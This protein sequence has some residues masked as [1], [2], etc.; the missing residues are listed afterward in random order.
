LASY[1]DLLR[2]RS[3]LPF[4]AGGALSFAAPST[5]VIVLV[6]ATA[7]AYPASLSQS[8]SFSALAL[9]ILGL[10]ATVPTLAAAI[11]SGTL[12]DR[13]DRR[14]L[15]GITNIA[16]VLAT[17][18]LV[19]VLFIHPD[20]HV[21]FPGPAGFYLPMWLVIACP[22][23]AGVTT[24][25]TFFRPAFNST[26]PR[27]VP[28]A[29]LG[30][31]NGLV[32]GVAVGAN[33]A[34][35]LSATALI[36]VAGVGWAL[37]VPF[38]LFTGTG[39]AVLAMRPPA[40]PRIAPVTR[41]TADV[42]EGYRFLY[43]NKALL[44]VTAASLLIN[45]LTALAFVELGLY[46]R[47]WLGVTEAILLGAMTTGATVGAGIGTI[48]AGRL[49]FERRAGRYLILLTAGQ[50]LTIMAL[51]LSHAI[52]FS[53]PLMVLFGIFPGMSATVFLATIQAVVPNRILGRV[54]AAD[55]VGSYGLVP[56]GQYA[57]GIVTLVAGVQVTFL[58]AGAGT[59]AVAGGM[60]SFSG[61]RKLGFDPGTPPA[62]PVPIAPVVAPLPTPSV[63]PPD[64]ATPVS[65]TSRPPPPG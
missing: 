18:A 41:F 55:E 48:F 5:V 61:L 30:R 29:A 49:G 65:G 3:F 58:L 42:V 52:W 47:D 28:A 40:G 2:T 54:L 1:Q 16:A 24:A 56:I 59:V 37:L 23:W 36:M 38:A 46:V 33:V 10:S 27:L 62:T 60:A 25:A 19:A 9:A 31:A 4:W 44:Q 14:W 51:A 39:L 43:R 57:G 8:P 21:A 13:F 6:W 32:Y 15:M 50:G 64:L 63:A 20:E 35:A 45:F 53:V 22:L 26:L 34:G 11:L 12:A 17:A 7:I